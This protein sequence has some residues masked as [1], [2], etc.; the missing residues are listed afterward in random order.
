MK[1]QLAL[2]GTLADA[3]RVL[4]AAHESIDLIELGTPLILRHGIDAAAHIRAAFPDLPLLADFKIM[5]AGDEEAAIAF[6]AGCAWATVL[7]A[8][9]DVT[10]VGAVAAAQRFGGQVMADLIGVSDPVARAGELIALGCNAVCVHTAYDTQ[11][12]GAH[13]LATLA[14]VR[15][16]WPD[17]AIGVAGGVRAES[18]AALAAYRPAIV[19][20]GGAITRA[21]EVGAAARAVRAAI[22][23]VSG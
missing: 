22:E 1:L 20:V 7:A 19:V 16:R 5:D 17:M 23:G 13:P 18:I 9:H 3:M 8:A 21:T 15:E 14:T 12:G 11:A 6:E 4:A 10:I 2:D